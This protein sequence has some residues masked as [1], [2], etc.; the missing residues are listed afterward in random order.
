MRKFLTIFIL[1]LV[2]AGGGFIYWKYFFVFG[3]GI[4]TGSLNYIVRKG[5]VFKTWE[6]KLI[7]EGIRSRTVG[8]IQSYEFEFSVASD[9]IANILQM[10]GGKIFDLHYKEYNGA[11][12][13]RGYSRYI[14][15]RVVGMREPNK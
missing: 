2:L 10:N 11:V 14:V 12:A 15:D 4:K 8:S 5:T 3:D 6:G 7:Q 1:V 13:W 9:S